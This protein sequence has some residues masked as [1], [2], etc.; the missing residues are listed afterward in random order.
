[1]SEWMFRKQSAAGPFAFF[2]DLFAR[3]HAKELLQFQATILRNV[4]ESVIVT[5]L[6]GHIIYWNEG[7]TSIFGYTAEDMLGKTPA[8]LYPEVSRTQLLPDL[9]HIL[10]GK[11]YIGEWRGQRKDGT[12]VW[13]HIKTTVLRNAKGEALGFI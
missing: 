13:V 10:A 5:D 4:S 1:M 7:A 12:T 9:Q 3:K 2:H 8:L 11:D 6:H